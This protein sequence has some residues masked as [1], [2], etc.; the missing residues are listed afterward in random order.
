MACAW[1]NWIRQISMHAGYYRFM[2]HHA[3]KVGGGRKEDPLAEALVNA[4]P[5]QRGIG[6][7]SVSDRI[8]VDIL[9]NPLWGVDVEFKTSTVRLKVRHKDGVVLLVVTYP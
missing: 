1:H 4:D 5:P 8:K 3:S 9:T 7:L 2:K 6:V